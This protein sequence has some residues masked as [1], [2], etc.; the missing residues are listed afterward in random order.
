MIIMR[1]Q[2]AAAVPRANVSEWLG[3]IKLALEEFSTTDPRDVAAF[4][5]TCAHEATNFT[6]LVENLNFSQRLSNIW[7]RYSSTGRRG[8]PPNALA[9]RLA[10]KPKAIANNVQA[11]RFGN[12]NEASGDGW[13]CRGRGIIQLSGRANYSDAARALVIDFVTRSELMEESSNAARTT[14]YWWSRN[15]ASRHGAVGNMLA[16]PRLV[17]ID[18]ANSTA[19]PH[20]WNDRRER[21]D[22]ALAAVGSVA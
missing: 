16:V 21:Y 18:N 8:G 14:G 15:G 12:G 11:D 3:P 22:L 10:R 19:M 13:R 4:L 5:A 2:F 9:M 1:E 20:G 7:K 17:N 6:Q